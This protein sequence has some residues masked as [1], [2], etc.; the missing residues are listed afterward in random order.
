MSDPL[1]SV[2]LPI[3]NGEKFLLEAVKSVLAQQHSNIEI[4]AV[5]DGS[6]DNSANLLAAEVSDSRLRVLRKTNGGVAS[7]RNHGARHANG[8][9][10]ALIDQDDAWYPHKLHEQIQEFSQEDVGLVGSLMRYAGRNGPM[11]ALSGEIADDQQERIRQGR[12]MPFAP[13]SIVFRTE[14]FRQVG[15]FDEALVREVAP[16]DDLDFVAKVASLSRVLTVRQELGIYRVHPSA[17]TFEKFF[18]MQLGTRFLQDR[19]QA[20]S[21]G[22]DISWADWRAANQAV[23]TRADKARFHYRMAG[24]EASG[25]NFVAAIRH[26]CVSLVLSP[27]YGGRRAARQILRRPKA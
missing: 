19:I 21:A 18:E 26:A 24:L 27:T 23:S 2:V 25:S 11:R 12:L 20:N 17:G 13:S 5:D 4:I 10:I 14:L 7:A 22:A 15:G 16:I 8:E 3:Y 1:V 6:T 9:F